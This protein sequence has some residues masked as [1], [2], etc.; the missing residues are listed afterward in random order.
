MGAR[1]CSSSTSLAAAAPVFLLLAACGGLTT[2]DTSTGEITG[3]I[4]GA[5]SSSM[6]YVLG[7]PEV[8]V[9]LAPDG[10]FTLPDV[11]VGTAKLVVFDG[12]NRADIVAVEVK[13]AGRSSLRK[14]SSELPKAGKL[15]ADAHC[16]DQKSPDGTEFEV[17]S[18][19][20]EATRLKATRKGGKVE[21]FP[22]PK[23]KWKLRAK[24]QGY[25]EN[26]VDVQV[27]DSAPDILLPD[28]ELV[29]AP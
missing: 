16:D 20:G 10:S 26:Q 24:Q 21:L 28:L 7:K 8:A 22:V 1:Q 12:G 18:D 14:D 17:T 11:P 19:A 2:P 15:T 4:T 23:G 27:D 3:Q 6:V 25:Y 29:R 9:E 13:G 5:Q